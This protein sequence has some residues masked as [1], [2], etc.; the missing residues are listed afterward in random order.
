M[1]EPSDP[2]D[3]GKSQS[4]IEHLLELR[5]RLLH[6]V[7]AVFGVFVLL[8]L[9]PAYRYLYYLVAA[10]LMHALPKGSSM[11]A[12]TVTSPFLVPMTLAFYVSLF[13]TMPYILHQIWA[14]ISPGLYR[15]ER[16][17]AL[18]L[19]VS[20]V[21]LFYAGCAFA[22]FVIFPIL[23][24][25]FTSVAPEGVA[26]MTDISSYL[27]FVV[28]IFIAFGISFE[29]PVFIVLL[30]ASGLVSHTTLRDKR[31]YVIVAC[32][33]IAMFLTPPDIFSQTLLAIPMCLLFEAGL[34][35]SRNIK[36]RSAEDKSAAGEG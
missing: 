21:L 26:V 19:L 27:S 4:L 16:K 31:R 8:M 14:F 9:T 20:S 1:T 23:F 34:F 22:Y 36:P 30:V 18:P 33:V 6:I 15:R 24:A 2:V 11:I 35:F 3:E 7:V 17:L 13:V 28:T 12:T 25:F 10:P 29:I 32:F 5:R